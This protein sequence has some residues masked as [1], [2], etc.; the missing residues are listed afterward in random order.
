MWV[1]HGLH[2]VAHCDSGAF[3]VNALVHEPLA[4][5]VFGRGGAGD[6]LR[7]KGHHA[8]LVDLNV[9]NVGAIVVLLDLVPE[10]LQSIAKNRV[11]ELVQSINRAG[12]QLAFPAVG[13]KSAIASGTVVVVRALFEAAQDVIH[14]VGVDSVAAL[15]ERLDE[16]VQ[17]VSY[18]LLVVNGLLGVVLVVLVVLVL[19]LVVLLIVL[20]VGFLDLTGDVQE[21]AGENYV[22]FFATLI[23]VSLVIEIPAHLLKSIDDVGFPLDFHGVLGLQLGEIKGAV[24]TS[25][26]LSLF[27]LRNHGLSHGP[28]LAA[29]D[30]VVV[31]LQP[32][33]HMS[34]GGDSGAVA[35]DLVALGGFAR[36]LY[37]GFFFERRCEQ[38]LVGLAF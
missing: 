2:P 32:V 36:L 34:Q 27:R 15:L 26:V 19:F 38:A 31:A 17:D 7:R 25:P 20:V 12:E 33:F 5:L 28:H 18:T 8:G 35:V 4:H 30:L 14:L 16:L 21:F 3:L 1:I 6:L 10:L 11:A 24:F 37:D 9:L 29:E 13:C 23:L 22:A